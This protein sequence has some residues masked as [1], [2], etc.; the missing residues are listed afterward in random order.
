M[1]IARRYFGMIVCIVG[2]WCVW[3]TEKIGTYSCSV[4]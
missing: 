4:R 1:V 2:K 3:S